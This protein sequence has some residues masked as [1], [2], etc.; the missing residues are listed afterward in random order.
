MIGLML[1]GQSCSGGDTKFLQVINSPDTFH[2]R[3]LEV[4]G[5]YHE[6]FEDVAIYLNRDNDKEKAIWL[7]IDD[8]HEEFDGKRIR[9]KGKFI[10]TDKGHLGEYIGTMRDAKILE[11]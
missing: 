5:I 6:R 10:A 7:D 1:L 2:R 4:S 8:S 11:D 3:E 9:L